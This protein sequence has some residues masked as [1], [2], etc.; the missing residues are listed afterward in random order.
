M[1]GVKTADHWCWYFLHSAAN[2]CIVY[3]SDSLY[4]SYRA[5]AEKCTEETRAEGHRNNVD[6]D[7]KRGTY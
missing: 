4:I 1:T 7:R 3:C 5:A 2:L 6:D